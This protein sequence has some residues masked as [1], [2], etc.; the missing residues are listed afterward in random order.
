MKGLWQEEIV[1]I[2]TQRLASR[3]K[4]LP[5]AA[6]AN[7]RRVLTYSDENFGKVRLSLDKKLIHIINE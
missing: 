4:H 6:Y 7:D 1:R 5:E 2:V 3:A